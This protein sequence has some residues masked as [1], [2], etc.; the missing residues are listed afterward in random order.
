MRYPLLDGCYRLKTGVSTSRTW[1]DH[2]DVIDP[3]GLVRLFEELAHRGE[4]VL[5]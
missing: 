4:V 2:T 5:E 3:R 1:E